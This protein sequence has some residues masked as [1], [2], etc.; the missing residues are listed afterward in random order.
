MCCEFSGSTGEDMRLLRAW[1]GGDREA[2]GALYRRHAAEVRQFFGRAEPEHGA[3]L[4]QDTFLALLRR[5]SCEPRSVRGYVMAIARNILCRHLRRKYKRRQE[6]ADYVDACV[7]A[8]PPTPGAAL[9]EQER[10]TAW[11]RAFDNLSGEEQE[12]LRLRYGE[13][14][15]VEEAA[16]RLHI[17]A[18][19]F[20]G[21]AQRAK[22]RLRRGLPQELLGRGE[23]SGGGRG[24]CG[25]GLDGGGGRGGPGG[26]GEDPARDLV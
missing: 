24:G 11:S 25:L 18:T 23:S 26:A 12:L 8:C 17:S 20:P 9:E 7:G 21:R 14:L 5:T 3:D 1:R 6:R 10:Q 15:S 16:R 19:T 2:A 4:V 22:Q 13:A